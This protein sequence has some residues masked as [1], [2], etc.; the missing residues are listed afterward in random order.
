M[1]ERLLQIHEL[2]SNQQINKLLEMPS[3][4]GQ[5]PSDMLP[6]M[7]QLC[8]AGEDKTAL[9]RWMFLRSLPDKVKLMLPE[10]HSSSVTQ[11]AARADKVTTSAPKPPA[12]A[13][14]VSV[15]SQPDRGRD[16]GRFQRGSNCRGGF[17]YGIRKWSAD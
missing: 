6:K 5:K 2:D 4:Q 3:L 1:K 10:D 15:P 8:P 17:Q 16:R 14:A 7:R 9:F 12:E 11:L 13:E